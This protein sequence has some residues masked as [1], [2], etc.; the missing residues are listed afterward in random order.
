[1]SPNVSTFHTAAFYKSADQTSTLC[2]IVPWLRRIRLFHSL[3]ALPR[4]ETDF[5]VLATPMRHLLVKGANLK[6]VLTVHRE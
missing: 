5:N 2:R 1:M 3:T 6:E 4:A